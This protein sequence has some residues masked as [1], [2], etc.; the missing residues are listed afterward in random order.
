MKTK[1][2][3]V[4]VDKK[5]GTKS[6]FSTKSYME[7]RSASLDIKDRQHNFFIPCMP[8]SMTHYF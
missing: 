2:R 8:F 3:A 7:Y 5:E 6:Y 4:D 1:T